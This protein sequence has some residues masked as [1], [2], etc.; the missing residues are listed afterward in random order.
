MCPVTLRGLCWDHE[1]CVS[2]MR[3]AAAAWQEQTGVE[4][5]W[6]ARPLD[7]RPVADI[8]DRYDLLFVGHPALGA[9]V[10]A[11]CLA[12]L[13]ELL[14]SAALR[15]VGDGSVG[16]SHASYRYDGRQWAL[17]ADAGC[18]VSAER[19][20]LMDRPAPETWD[21]VLALARDAPGAVA[22]PL[23]PADVLCALLTLCANAGRPVEGVRGFDPNAISLLAALATRVDPACFDADAPALLDRMRDGDAIAYV[24]LIFGYTNY[25]RVD[26]PNIRLRFGAIP[27]TAGAILGGSGLAVS[28]ASSSAGEAAAFARWVCDAETQ[29]GLVGPA[30]GQ[31]AHR[32]AWEDTALD[33]VCGRFFSRTR[34]TLEAAWMRPREPWWPDFQVEAGELLVSELRARSGPVD[35]AWRLNELLGR[36][37]GE[38]TNRLAS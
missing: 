14:D 6:D 24:P 17:A 3:A 37:R 29:P 36:H 8:A 23:Q 31:P 32:A 30:G 18:H 4:I 9:A 10:G 7:E 33:A 20:S 12:P 28:A 13:D 35:I 34:A 21:E 26:D 19:P 38:P 16:P 25:S 1:R 2:P 15:A 5:A 22:L 27:G 11:G